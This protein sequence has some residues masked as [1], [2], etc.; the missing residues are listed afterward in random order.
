MEQLETGRTGDSAA[1]GSGTGETMSFPLQFIVQSMILNYWSTFLVPLVLVHQKTWVV[2]AVCGY[3]GVME[4]LALGKVV[5]CLIAL[6][7][8]KLLHNLGPLCCFQELLVVLETMKPGHPQ[9]KWWGTTLSALLPVLVL[10][11]DRALRQVHK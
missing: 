8:T 7:P 10:G 6:L 9:E 3:H 4:L 11:Q 2:L 5:S 1:G